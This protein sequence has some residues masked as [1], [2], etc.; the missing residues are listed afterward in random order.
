MCYASPGPRCKGHAQEKHD[1]IMAKTQETWNKVRKVED[2]IKSMGVSNND[3]KAYVKLLKKRD[4]LYSDWQNLSAKQ[5][6]AKKEIDATRGGLQ[7]IKAKIA[8][9]SKDGS[10]DASLQSADL[11]MREE[12]GTRIYNERMLA[13]DKKKETVDGRTPSPYGDAQGI[14]TLTNR[15]KKLRAKYDRAASPDE[16]NEIYVK[17]QA[18]VKARDHAVKTREHASNGIIN[19]YKASLKTNQENLKKAQTELK[20]ASE[21][22]EETTKQYNILK[23]D[24]IYINRHERMV[25]R[26]LRSS[27]SPAAE[28]RVAKQEAKVKEYNTNHHYPAWKAERD[29]QAKVEEYSKNLV[30]ARVSKTELKRTYGVNS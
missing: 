29:A 4:A 14:Q 17:Y 18:A 28:A 12:E 11:F 8:E 6:E 25:A 9:L 2:E 15:A 7:D 22:L 16:R 5:K 30:K 23:E 19:P 3:S 1:A 13:Y 26:G 27:Y 21:K 20:S 10:T 24:S